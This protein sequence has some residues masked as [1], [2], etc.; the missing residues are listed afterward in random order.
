MLSLERQQNALVEI[1]MLTDLFVL[2]KKPK[3][4]IEVHQAHKI[5][6]G[7]TRPF[8]AQGQVGKIF[9]AC[10]FKYGR[11]IFHRKYPVPVLGL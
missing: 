8:A 11:I 4:H 1:L 10:P 7:V 9:L 6:G 2:M 5:G 3:H